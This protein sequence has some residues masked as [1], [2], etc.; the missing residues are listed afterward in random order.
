M[1]LD[2][3]E[4][5]LS[6]VAV[7]ADWDDELSRRTVYAL[8]AHRRAWLH[9]VRPATSAV[10]ALATGV[11]TNISAVRD[12][13]LGTVVIRVNGRRGHGDWGAGLRAGWAERARGLG[14]RATGWLGGAS[15]GIGAQGYGLAGRSAMG[16]S[17]RVSAAWNTNPVI[18]LEISLALCPPWSNLVPLG[19]CT[20]AAVSTYKG[21]VAARV[22]AAARAQAWLDLPS[23]VRT[24]MAAAVAVRE[25]PRLL[26]T[27][28]RVKT[29]S[30]PCAWVGLPP[31]GWTAALGLDCRAWVGLPDHLRDAACTV[32]GWPSQRPDSCC[33]CGPC[34]HAHDVRNAFGRRCLGR[35]CR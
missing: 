26:L 28:T 10:P 17:G 16:S 5:L 32:G 25:T 31:L 1:P 30:H 34:G 11:R 35:S 4:L 24:Q 19:F 3:T 33:S 13:T 8:T 9:G 29:H 6:P 20:V 15:T 7:P 2:G 14:R 27:R 21:W 18:T 12:A 23:N 22:S